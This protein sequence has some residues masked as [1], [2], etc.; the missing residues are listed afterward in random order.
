MLLS[1]LV[2][3]SLSS[4]LTAA[5][6]EDPA[7]LLP[8]ETLIYFG[9]TSMH[10][11][12]EASKNTAM[13]RILSE[14]EVKSFLHSPL[15]AANAV[16]ASGLE[17]VSGQISEAQ[18]AAKQMGLGDN[19]DL[20]SFEFNL[21]SS[22][23]PIG[24]VFFALT[25]VLLPG[26]AGNSMP[27]V[28][29]IFGVE[30]LDDAMVSQL[31][32]LWAM[33]PAE[34]SKASHGGVEYLSKSIPN[35]PVSVHLAFLDNLAVLS[36]SD[37]AINGMIDR[38]HGTNSSGSLAA[39]ADY[40]TMIDAAGGLLPGGSSNLLRVSPI[41]D[42]CRMAIAMG[43]SQDPSISPDQLALTLSLFDGMGFSSIRMAGGVSAV[44][45]DGMI[46]TTSVLS[47]DENGPGLISKLSRGVGS[48]DLD[49]LDSVPAD[50]LSASANTLGTRIV[51][52]YDF[53]WDM[54][55]QQSEEQAAEIEA[56][57]SALLGGVDLRNDLLANVQGTMTSLSTTGQGLMGTPDNLMTMGL[58]D[59][60]KFVAALG[61]LLDIASA[62][63][64]MP[65]SLK[66]S[67]FDGAPFYEIDLSATPFGMAM[68]PAF[69]IRNGEMVMGTNKRGLQTYLQ[70]GIGSSAPLSDN[71]R[72][73]E[74]V[75][76]L[77][78]QGDVEA[79]AY[80]DLAETFGSTYGML[81]GTAQMFP[82]GDEIPLDMSKV[83]PANTISQHLMQT[84]SGAYSG[85]GGLKVSRSV[86]QFQLTDFLPL[87]MVAGAI[88]AGTQV[89]GLA[90]AEIE[91]K[92]D[93]AEKARTDLRELKASITVYKISAQGYPESLADLLIPLGTDFPQGAYPHGELPVDPWGNS[94]RYAMEMHTKKRRMM[95]K[96]WSIG[97]NGIDESGEGDDILKF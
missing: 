18:A 14:S 84:Y 8:A 22:E 76:G 6:A 68:S 59:P 43:M 23:P 5:P 29:L 73:M 42:I 57:L 21:D 40:K 80:S 9:S 19:V 50:C 65:L 72:F 31:K 45:S 67:E 4:L 71:K 36:T 77:S 64:G 70:E 26:M 12:W 86:S 69:A 62:Q 78:S 3:L 35:A 83:P 47:I 1:S 13:A 66:E 41:A 52:V 96:L 32:D 54:I 63:I 7:S 38:H 81:V 33:L 17:M 15:A 55:R 93:P 60:A 87:F 24:Q 58:R 28:G 11:S 16:L 20:D 39:S 74:F 79:F 2:A 49:R 30:L 51:D 44:G 56:Q 34:G 95:P 91:V 61:S 25:H 90:P 89:P 97:L 48:V 88:V 75:N 10:T 82:M 46:Y 27:D 92:V 85:Q 94:Y 37:T 53:A